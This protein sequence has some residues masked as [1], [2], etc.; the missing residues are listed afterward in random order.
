[1]VRPELILSERFIKTIFLLLGVGILLPW[2]AYISAKQYFAS[3]FCNETGDK[4]NYH[5]IGEEI[6]MWFSIVY[7]GASVLSLVVVI[8]VQHIADSKKY[9]NKM[10]S[11]K[12][13]IF[14][15]TANLS[16]CMM[17]SKTSSL[18]N[19]DTKHSTDHTIRY[20]VIIPLA[21]YLI[22]FAVSTLL[23]FVPSLPNEMF[24]LLTL[25]GLF[26]CGVCTAI[27]SSGIVGT[28]GLFSANL[29]VNP[30]FNGQAIGGLLVSCANFIASFL[31]GPEH[32]LLQY[33]SDQSLSDTLMSNTSITFDGEEYQ[34][35][36]GGT[37]C[38]PY[39]EISFATAG[40]FSMGGF[41]LVA[42]MVGY[43]Y[44]DRY[45]RLVRKNSISVKDKNTTY[46]SDE[47]ATDGNCDD[48]EEW[49]NNDASQLLIDGPIPHF[50]KSCLD[51][52]QGDNLSNI[53]IPTSY[54]NSTDL[55]QVRRQNSSDTDT[56][57]STQS[58][59]MS[60]WTSVRGTALSLFFTYFCTLAIFPVWTSELIST[61]QCSTPSRIRNDLFVPFSFIIFNGGDLVGRYIS[62][63]IKFERISNL[64]RKLV[65]TSVTRIFLL[66]SLFLSCKARRDPHDDWMD[67]DNDLYSWSIQF[68]FAISNGILTNVAF[69]Y[70]PTL[71]ENRTKPQQVAS[72]ILNLAL[73]LGLTIGSLFSVPFLKFASGKWHT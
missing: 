31:D 61:S 28:A 14:K 43:N 4:D 62:S 12:S 26:I 2:N 45:K 53:K 49:S 33:C 56:S 70:A 44:I 20:M 64:S 58:L 47:I 9:N 59:T 11:V 65:W 41:I 13:F 15:N 46:Y 42:C 7:N 19:I 39:G 57:E 51:Q 34:G 48:D 72:A 21:V 60:V 25:S 68:L 69:C 54:Q 17:S 55:N 6:E 32:F 3:R 29:G 36:S 63:A 38:I 27:A 8:L 1:M 66:F 16:V 10:K 22:V 23:V 67:V 24:L 18:N 73:T 30:F 35:V 37:I 52:R 40:Y 71:V 5:D 50:K